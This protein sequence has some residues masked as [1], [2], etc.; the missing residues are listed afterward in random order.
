MA[1]D[2]ETSLFF[3][4]A[5]PISEVAHTG[6]LAC[7]PVLF[8]LRSVNVKDYPHIR[9]GIFFPQSH[10]SCVSWKMESP[11]VPGWFPALALTGACGGQLV[12]A[13]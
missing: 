5:L 1:R 12:V 10:V 2:S 11:G 3:S 7:R 8:R 6:V 9:V 13:V 4:W